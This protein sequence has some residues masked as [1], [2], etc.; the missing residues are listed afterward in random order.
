MLEDLADRLAI[1]LLIVAY[2]Q[3][4]QGGE[5]TRHQRGPPDQAA[6]RIPFGRAHDLALRRRGGTREQREVGQ[7]RRRHGD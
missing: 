1:G 7:Q 5:R 4:E 6:C 2:E 3:N